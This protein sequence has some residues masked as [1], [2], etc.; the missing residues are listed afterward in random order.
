MEL[1]ILNIRLMSYFM[2][3]SDFEVYCFA[4]NKSCLPLILETLKKNQIKRIHIL[5]NKIEMSGVSI[6]DFNKQFFEKNGITVVLIPY[7]EDI[8]QTKIESEIILKWFSKNNVKKLVV[9]CPIFHILRASMTIISSVIDKNYS[10]EVIPLSSK[11]K[12]W[13]VK[14]ITHQGKNENN[15]WNLTQDEIKRVKIYQEKGDIKENQEI[16]NYLLYY[17]K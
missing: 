9:V 14:Y 8:I 4:H 12:D 1:S 6:Y 10:I 13:G 5:E 16:F 11:V 15:I 2:P 17:N 3:K 7:N